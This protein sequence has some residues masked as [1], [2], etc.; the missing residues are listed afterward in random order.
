MRRILL[1]FLIFSITQYSF[2]GQKNIV[3]VAQQAK[4]F[5]TLIA[6]VKAAGLA[7]T[8]SNSGKFT[9]FAPTDEAFAKLPAGTLEY[10]LDNPKVLRSILLY[11]LVPGVIKAKKV[12]QKYLMIYKKS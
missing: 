5:N 12:L 4:T 11:H 7:D 9:V 8:L 2:A 6:A 10:L 3:E 1:A